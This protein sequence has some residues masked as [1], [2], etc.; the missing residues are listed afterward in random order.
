MTNIH[1]N[2]VDLK[3]NKK[4]KA[5]VLI[6]QPQI[7][8][9]QLNL[10]EEYCYRLELNH[11]DKVFIDQVLKESIK[12]QVDV[13]VFPEFSVP[14]SYHHA[15]KEF[16]NQNHNILIIAGTDYLKRD[17]KYYNTASIFF[18]G[19]DYYTYK[20]LLSPHEV[21]S[22]EEQGPQNGIIFNYFVNTPAGNIAIMICMDA[23]DVTI[24]NQ[25]PIDHIDIL[26]VIAFQKDPYEHHQAIDQIVKNCC[27]N[28]YIAYAN[29][30]CYPLSGGRS[31][32]FCFNY[33]DRIQR[34]I[35]DGLNISDGISWR[36]IQMP[37]KCGCLIVECNIKNKTAHL[38]NFKSDRSPISKLGILVFE[39]ET[40][41]PYEPLRKHHKKD[42]NLPDEKNNKTDVKDWKEN[43]IS[44][45]NNISSTWTTSRMFR[46]EWFRQYLYIASKI[47]NE[48]I[49]IP[50]GYLEIINDYAH[51][52]SKDYMGG[53]CPGQDNSY[54]I[55]TLKDY[56][57]TIN[58]CL[59]SSNY[60]EYA[61]IKYMKEFYEIKCLSVNFLFKKSAEIIKFVFDK[62]NTPS[63][64]ILAD[65][66]ATVLYS[67]QYR[68]HYKW[69][70][71]TSND[72]DIITGS[73]SGLKSLKKTKKSLT[74]VADDKFLTTS[75]FIAASIEK[76]FDL[77]PPKNPIFHTNDVVT[78]I[79]N[80]KAIGISFGTFSSMFE[81]PH[82]I[83]DID[84]DIPK[85]AISIY[86][87][88][89]FM[90]L[91]ISDVFLYCFFDTI[92]ELRTDDNKRNLV[93]DSIK[94]DE[95]YLKKVAETLG[96][97]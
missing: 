18:N 76:R 5:K 35:H 24:R 1:L 78:T 25:Y 11:N 96:L 95:L 23:L 64:I 55:E 56:S 10:G 84:K 51:E 58:I 52:V 53:F 32:L 91:K 75:A 82:I 4:D 19:N 40:L 69:S 48:N 29:Y 83:Q 12:N 71:C 65:I 72:T 38:G 74:Y 28:I 16:S 68:G 54:L 9:N 2:P 49:Y 33:K 14:F 60:L 67:D 6:V 41:T 92:R 94:K 59:V 31:S 30:L 15:I 73:L 87:E 86:T 93:L 57:E 88:T 7:K 36:N 22:N 42:D 66:P 27:E 34:Y 89:N 63:A 13:V 61:A 43:T 20:C 97:I 46:I 70:G 90:N 81:N 21:A 37:T 45:I 62:N 39:N 8:E 77:P 47:S 80:E 3:C 50:E 85:I 44:K 17:E 26:C 79:K